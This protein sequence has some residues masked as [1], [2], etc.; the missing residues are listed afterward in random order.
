M[1][2]NVKAL[3]LAAGK[4]TRLQTEGIDLPKVMRQADGHPLL[5]YVLRGLSFLP[6]AFPASSSR[7]QPTPQPTR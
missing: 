2:H 6:P 4:C 3:V 7:A 5:Y 1:D